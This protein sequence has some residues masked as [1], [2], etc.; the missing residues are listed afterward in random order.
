MRGGR[1]GGR[2]PGGRG[3]AQR[4][5]AGARPGRSRC[6]GVELLNS[7][8]GGCPGRPGRCRAPEGSGGPGPAVAAP[9]LPRAEARPCPGPDQEL[10]SVPVLLSPQGGVPQGVGTQGT[11]GAGIRVVISSSR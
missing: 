5:A 4:A 8:G 10:K 11:A 6:L 7:G 3:P 2:A 1:R 9:Q